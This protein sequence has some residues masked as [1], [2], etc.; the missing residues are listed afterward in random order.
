MAQA[1]DQIVL[2]TQFPDLKLLNRGKVRDIYEIEDK[3][4]IVATDRI[5]AFDHILP[6]GIPGKGRILTQLSLFWF[7]LVR[8]IIPNHLITAEVSRFP[9]QTKKYAE[10]LEG[11]SILVKKAKVWPV[12]CVVRGYLAGSGWAEYQKRGTVC[13]LKLPVG[14]EQAAKLPIPIFTPAIKA[15]TGHDENINLE[16]MEAI[17]GQSNARQLSQA[18]VDIYKKAADYALA[19]GVIIADTKFEFGL[20]QGKIILVDE[21]LTPDSSRFWPQTS[22]REGTNPP[23]YDKQY[24]RDYLNSIGWDKEPPVPPLPEEVVAKTAEKYRQAVAQLTGPGTQPL[25]PPPGKI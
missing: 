9:T 2:K 12:E 21:I 1:R 11:R 25:A 6:T 23:S 20:Y 18:S 22:Y 17:I 5:S 16:Q 8:D 14:L 10:I 15:E 24:V 4:L 13:G 19:K 7:D 3:L